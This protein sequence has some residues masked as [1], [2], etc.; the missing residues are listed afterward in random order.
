M[1][2]FLVN[3]NFFKNI[4]SNNLLRFTLVHKFINEEN[5]Q[6]CWH[7]HQTTH[8]ERIQSTLKQTTREY[9]FLQANNFDKTF[10]KTLYKMN[11][12]CG[13]I[14]HGQHKI[15]RWCFVCVC[16]F[17]FIGVFCSDFRAGWLPSHE[18]YT[19]HK[20][21][22]SIECQWFACSMI[23]SCQYFRLVLLS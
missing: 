15:R 17:F 8:R 13:M 12:Y 9:K 18:I 1:F 3:F 10:V 7:H 4:S 22:I 20:W 14:K 16:C 19:L 2:P 23:I 5:Y 11:L 21:S 6:R